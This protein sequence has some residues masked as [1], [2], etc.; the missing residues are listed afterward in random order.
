MDRQLPHAERG[1]AELATAAKG[2]TVLRDED[3]QE[4]IDQVLVRKLLGRP[5]GLAACWRSSTTGRTT[6]S[7]TSCATRP[8]T[9]S[10]PNHTTVLR[11]VERRAPTWSP[12]FVDGI[13]ADRVFLE[14]QTFAWAVKTD[15]EHPLRKAIDTF[16]VEFAGELQRDDDTIERVERIKYQIVEHPTVQRFI[17]QAWATVKKLVLDAAEDPSSA[18]RLR[19]R[20]GLL[21]LGRAAER[22]AE[23]RGKIDG[24]LVEAA[25]TCATT[26]ARSRR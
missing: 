7:S 25:A 10:R 11:I 6:G 17:G 8:T 23:L 18:L 14:V 20:D 5:A 12:R 16:L 26:A 3:V 21:A 15:P 13:I 4:V 1:T 19:V 2:V 9:V 24:W 22:D